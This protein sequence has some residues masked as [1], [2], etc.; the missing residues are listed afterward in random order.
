[1]TVTLIVEDGTKPAFANTYV[2]AVN[3]DAYHAAMGNTDWAGNDADTRAQALILAT[4]AVDL[5]YGAKYESYIYFNSTQSLLFPRAQFWDANYRLITDKT[6]PQ[7]LMNAVCEIAQMQIDGTD[8]FP[9]QSN[10]M[11]IK[12]ESVKVGGL[13]VS[14]DYMKTLEGESFDGFRKIDLLIRP[15][16]KQKTSNW[17]L[18]P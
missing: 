7:S 18:N 3:A 8:I 1:M 11:A 15:L 16:L 6:I 14:T 12:S 13:S 10:T 17:P 4:Q 2:S 9:V 5:L